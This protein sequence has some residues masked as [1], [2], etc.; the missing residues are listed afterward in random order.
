MKKRLIVLASTVGVAGLIAV[1]GAAYGSAFNPASNAEANAPAEPVTQESYDAAYATFRD[2]MKD[3]GA[4][5]F[6]ERTVG[7]VHDFSYWEEDKS[8]YD[9][10]YVD[11]APVDFRWQVANSYD[12]PTYVSLRECLTDLG[13]EPGKDAETVW[14]QV[15]AADID[16]VECTLGPRFGLATSRSD[17]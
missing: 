2:C 8:A 16:V 15:R 10:C 9:R 4:P 1:G 14:E 12:S 3:A 6:S 13:V 17:C 5:I 11:F 7:V